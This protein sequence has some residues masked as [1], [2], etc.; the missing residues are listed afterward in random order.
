MKKWNE[1]STNEK[2]EA[3]ASVIPSVE[4]DYC[5]T[6][7]FV[8]NVLNAMEEIEQ[9]WAECV[10]KAKLCEEVKCEDCGS[11]NGRQSPYGFLCYRCLNN[12]TRNRNDAVENE[13]RDGNGQLYVDRRWK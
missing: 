7:L 1:C 13:T 2:A 3:I 11:E 5:K 6:V 10:E 8:E 4:G 12:E 9:E